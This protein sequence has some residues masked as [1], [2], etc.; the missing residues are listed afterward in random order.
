M[1]RKRMMT[2]MSVMGI[3]VVEIDPVYPFHDYCLGPSPT[4]VQPLLRGQPNE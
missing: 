1:R 4:I 2:I 3:L